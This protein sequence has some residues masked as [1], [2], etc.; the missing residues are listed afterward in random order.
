MKPRNILVATMLLI[1]IASCKKD[2]PEPQSP[3]NGR[4]TAQFNP[5]KEYGTVTDIDGNEYKTIRIGEQE[6]MAENL[7]VTHYQNG[8]CITKI[9][10]RLD[11]DS[12]NYG[13]FFRS[14]ENIDTIA[15]YG[16]LYDWKAANDERNIAPKGWRI[17]NANDWGKLGAYFG[18]YYDRSY[19]DLDVLLFIISDSITGLKLK[20][21]GNLHWKNN[22]DSPFLNISGFTAL[23]VSKDTD[24]AYYWIKDRKDTDTTAYV[25]GC[26]GIMAGGIDAWYTYN[27]LL[28][29]RCIKIKH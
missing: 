4:T 7:R 18:N 29:I 5:K 2:A 23:P 3:F 14:T 26:G 15:T 21:K 11:S 1:S 10:Y 28:P 13:V 16:L 9:D 6:W 17:P 12:L 27:K 22:P 20:E 19:S 8:D 24:D 25:Y